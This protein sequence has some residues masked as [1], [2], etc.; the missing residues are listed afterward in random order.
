[1]GRVVRGRQERLGHPVC[2]RLIAGTTD[3]HRDAVE[4]AA[5]Y[6]LIEHQVAPRFYDRD[7]RACPTEW[8][9][10]VR[11]HAEVPLARRCWPPGWCATTSSN[12]YAPAAKAARH[13]GR[14]LRRRRGSSRRGA[15]GCRRLEG[16]RRPPRR[17][18]RRGRP[19]ARRRP[20]VAR[21]GRPR[22]AAARPMS[23]Y[24]RCSAPSTRDNRITSATMTLTLAERT[25]T[26]PRLVRRRHPADAGRAFGYTVR[27]LP[28]HPLLANPAET[29]PGRHGR[30]VGLVHAVSETWGARTGCYGAPA[31]TGP[32]GRVSAIRHRGPPVDLARRHLVRADLR[33][34]RIRPE[35]VARSAVDWR[36]PTGGRRRR[37]RAVRWP[38][39]RGGVGT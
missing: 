26:R 16:R 2:R 31:P 17:V 21:R 29:G 25:A 10:M 18:Q 12:L 32:A 37:R 39:V 34:G 11:L 30:A 24:R 22:R 28:T 20:A 4:A 27:V 15:T 13:G 35:Q 33:P 14:R 9:A 38:C 5:L 19:A 8:V 7:A 6:D 1:M 23:R 3:D 36:D